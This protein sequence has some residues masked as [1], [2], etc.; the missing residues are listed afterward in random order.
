MRKEEVSYCIVERRL[1]DIETIYI[2]DNK[3][4]IPF[5]SIEFYKGNN[6][7][8]ILGS[9]FDFKIDDKKYTNIERKEFD[10]IFKLGLGI[11]KEL[12]KK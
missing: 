10:K 2:K 1:S 3:A 4:I 11:L 7:A 9:I 5:I 8:S 12:S 6:M